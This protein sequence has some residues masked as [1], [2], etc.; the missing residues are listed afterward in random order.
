MLEFGLTMTA[1]AEEADVSRNTLYRVFRG[2][3]A[4]AE[5]SALDIARRLGFDDLADMIFP[6]RR[7]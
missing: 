4:S 7:L 2:E 1:L 5:G 3:G 6:C